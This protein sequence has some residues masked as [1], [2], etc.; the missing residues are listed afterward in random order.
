MDVTGQWIEAMCERSTIGAKLRLKTLFK[1]YEKWA[2]DEV[3][4]T[5]SKAETCGSVAGT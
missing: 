2:L 1:S 5:V 3:G 4:A